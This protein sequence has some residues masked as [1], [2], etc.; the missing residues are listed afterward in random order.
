MDPPSPATEL[1]GRLWAVPHA[2]GVR[3]GTFG[4][5]ADPPQ[6][7]PWEP[8]LGWAEEGFPGWFLI[9]IYF[10]EACDEPGLGEGEKG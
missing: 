6:R 9:H 8:K 10:Q 3:L 7:L 4:L 2:Q 1:R 5:R